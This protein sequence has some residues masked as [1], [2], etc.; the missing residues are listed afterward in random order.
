MTAVALVEQLRERGVRIEL[1]PPDGVRCGPQSL[2]TSS[3][4]AALRSHKAAVRQLLMDEAA[5][6]VPPRCPECQ[7]L[8]VWVCGW[9]A[10]GV[11]QWRCVRCDATEAGTMR[12]IYATLTPPE[13]QQLHADAHAGDRL[14]QIIMQMLRA[15]AR[16]GLG[17]PVDGI[18]EAGR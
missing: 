13:Q 11:D 4:L 16:R 3:D 15:G 8:T 10:P 9:P 6:E 18:G 14:A 12:A 7:G 5:T 1:V 2:V 17:N